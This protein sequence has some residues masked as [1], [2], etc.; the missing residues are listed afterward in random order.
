MTTDRHDL[1]LGLLPDHGRYH[2]DPFLELRAKLAD[3]PVGFKDMD[4]VTPPVINQ[5]RVGSCALSATLLAMQ[6]ALAAQGDPLG[7]DPS[8]RDGYSMALG[9]DRAEAEPFTPQDELAPLV[10]V[11]TSLYTA[12]EVIRSWGVARRGRTIKFD[13]EDTGT[14][15]GEENATDEPGLL[16]VEQAS[17]SLIIGAYPLT[18]TGDN[19]DKQ[20]Q[21]SLDAN[22]TVV[23]GGF[24]D[25]AHFLSHFAGDPPIGAQDLSDPWGGGHATFLNGY[26]LDP[27]LGWLYR[28]QNSHGKTW[29]YGGRSWVTSAFVRQMWQVMA[30]TVRKAPR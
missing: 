24:V 15:C 3:T 17:E 14:D 7:F 9:L 30:M 19:L 29:G 2:R 28:I 11:G 18:A 27:V 1:G 25:Y 6:T 4:S 26:K 23:L 5:N 22:A 13:G 10:D 8:V 20:I 21:L 16:S 12:V